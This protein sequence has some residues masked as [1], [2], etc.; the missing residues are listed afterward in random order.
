RTTFIIAH[1]LSTI[2]NAD[3]I[4]FAKNGDIIERGTYQELLERKGEYFELWERQNRQTEK[5]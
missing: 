2:I 3:L 1:R 4:L 5:K